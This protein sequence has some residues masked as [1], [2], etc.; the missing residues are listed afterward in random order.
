MSMN[1]FDI[2]MTRVLL[3]E[4][5]LAQAKPLMGFDCE[6]GIYHLLAFDFGEDGGAL[7]I[8]RE[9]DTFCARITLDAL[10]AFSRRARAATPAV[11]TA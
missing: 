4:A 8:W 6:D 2:P 5:T 7:G 1:H 11:G 3:P 10:A 9:G